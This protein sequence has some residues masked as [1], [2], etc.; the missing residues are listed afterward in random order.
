MK[1]YLYYE[2]AFKSDYTWLET[3][4]EELSVMVEN[5][6]HQRQMAAE[7]PDS[8]SL[9]DAQQ[10]LNE[11]L[12]RPSYNSWHKHSRHCS[13]FEEY[14]VDDN[15]VCS[16]ASLEDEIREIRHADLYEAISTLDPDQKELLT[17]VYWDGESQTDIAREMGVSTVAITQRMNRIYARLR[18]ELAR[19][20]REEEE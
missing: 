5:D 8:V 20:S 7:D 18:K 14:N 17:R 3:D 1:L 12:N 2:S 10:I 6:Y 19:I 13:S 9:R 4:D 11:D 15:R 16:P